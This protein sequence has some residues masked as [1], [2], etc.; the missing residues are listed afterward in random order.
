M[1]SSWSGVSYTSIYRFTTVLFLVFMTMSGYWTILIFQNF[2]KKPRKDSIICNTI[3]CGIFKFFKSMASSSGVPGWF[4]GIIVTM[5]Y[6]GYIFFGG[7]IFM[8]LERPREVEIC[9]NMQRSNQRAQDTLRKAE[10]QLQ[11]ALADA[12]IAKA[13][14]TTVEENVRRRK[15]ETSEKDRDPRS[16][17]RP[18]LGVSYKLCM[19]SYGSLE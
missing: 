1:I 19:K 17:F 2:R 8:L 3:F 18:F 16:Y 11:E 15:R 10:L 13:I 14:D 12:E 7:L 4:Y 6:F 9:Q 5:L